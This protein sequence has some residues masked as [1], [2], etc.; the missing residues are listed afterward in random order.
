MGRLGGR[1]QV[2]GPTQLGKLALVVVDVCAH[3]VVVRIKL[4]LCLTITAGGTITEALHPT[5]RLIR[6]LGN[7]H[8]I[9]IP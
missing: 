9:Q 1:R 7:L 4:A 8:R 3:T 6:N 5:G 2:V